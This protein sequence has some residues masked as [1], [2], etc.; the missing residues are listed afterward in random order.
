MPAH[1]LLRHRVGS[2]LWAPGS[3]CKVLGPP[4]YGEHQQKSFSSR[5]PSPRDSQRGELAASSN[6]A[7]PQ[8]AVTPGHRAGQECVRTRTQ[9]VHPAV[10]TLQLPPASVSTK[11]F[12]ETSCE[13]KQALMKN[14]SVKNVFLQSLEYFVLERRGRKIIKQPR[15]IPA[16]ALGML[17]LCNPRALS[18]GAPSSPCS[19]QAPLVPR[20]H[21][22]K[23]TCCGAAPPQTP[24]APAA[25]PPALSVGTEAPSLPHHTAS[26]A[27]PPC[28]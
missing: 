6:A 2:G 22:S 10:A 13:R 7:C 9:P 16:L 27:G 25:A 19:Y 26:P 4:L 15:Y 8:R 24:P 14:P 21:G 17:M 5:D 18:G 12:Q 28:S 20:C 11:C 1:P 3:V 23:S